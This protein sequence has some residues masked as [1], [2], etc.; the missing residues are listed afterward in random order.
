MERPWMSLIGN[1]WCRIKTCSG[2]KNWNKERI[3]TNELRTYFESQITVIKWA[4][5]STLCDT[6]ISGFNYRAL[7]NVLQRGRGEAGTSH[8]IFQPFL[9]YSRFLLRQ[10][11]VE[12]K[13]VHSQC[14]SGNW[15]FL[16]MKHSPG[17]DLYCYG[18]ETLSLKLKLIAADLFVSLSA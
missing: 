8:Q 5:Y 1:V 17:M 12:S 15:Y 11:K 7:W 3:S 13:I 14:F 18:T 16:L 6:G 4:L 2:C 9:Q 10:S